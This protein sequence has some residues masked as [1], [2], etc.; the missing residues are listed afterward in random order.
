MVD[1]VVSTSLAAFLAKVGGFWS[2]NQ[3]SL[4]RQGVL[5]RD[6][7]DMLRQQRVLPRVD[8]DVSRQRGMVPRDGMICRRGEGCFRKFYEFLVTAGSD[9]TRWLWCVA[10]ARGAPTTFRDLLSA[11]VLSRWS[12]ARRPYY[13]VPWICT[14]ISQLR[15]FLSQRLFPDSLDPSRNLSRHPVVVFKDWWPAF[16]ATSFPFVEIVIFLPLKD[17]EGTYTLWPRLSLCNRGLCYRNDLINLY[18]AV[19]C[20]VAWIGFGSF[21]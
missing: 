21:C 6:G 9:S 12:A 4:W 5:Q 3:D 16:I 14:L 11:R 2:R 17:F 15:G 20:H 10:T 7:H 13:P 1:G 18:Y 8:H 19:G